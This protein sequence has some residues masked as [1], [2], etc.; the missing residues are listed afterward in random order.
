[1]IAFCGVP[2]DRV[3]AVP[4]GVT[5]DFCPADP[6]E[7]AEF[8]RRKG[9]PQ[10]FILFLGTLEPRKNLVRL[11]DAY[12]AWRQTSREP[13]PLV[14]AGGKGWFYETIFAPAAELGLGDAV[15][16][17]GYIPGDELPWW[18]RAARFV[19]PSYF[20]GFGLPVLEAAG[21]RH[22]DDHHPGLLAP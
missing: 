4:N 12:A 3:V 5:E 15:I 9:L 2:A 14:L 8:R 22:A 17:P 13:V 21:L 7:I 20:E 1:M 19:Y 16:F 10:R 6:R 18:Y 11:L